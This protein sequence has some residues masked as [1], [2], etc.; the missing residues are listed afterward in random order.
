MLAGQPLDGVIC[1]LSTS[2]DVLAIAT[3]DGRVKTYDT[4]ARNE[5]A[6]APAACARSGAEAGA[7]AAQLRA[8]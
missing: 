3:P 8:S 2:G 4:G 7:A 1:S 5:Q 6:A